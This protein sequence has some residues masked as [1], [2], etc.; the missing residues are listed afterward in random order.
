MEPCPV[1][2]ITALA[3]EPALSAVDA[4]NVR[5]VPAG[6]TVR[7]SGVVADA[8]IAILVASRTTER[9]GVPTGAGNF[10]ISLS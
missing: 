9:T 2:G 7:A 8:R 4:D 6:T 3:F 5:I 1:Y 10:R